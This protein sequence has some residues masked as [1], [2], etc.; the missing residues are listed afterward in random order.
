MSGASQRKPGVR[1]P[2][3]LRWFFAIFAPWFFPYTAALAGIA[4]LV[5]LPS[6]YSR[7]EHALCDRAVETLLASHDLVEVTRAGIIVREVGCN[8]GG[9]LSRAGSGVSP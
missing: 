6:P 7:E 5:S 1:V 2:P 9:R 8:I 4:Y 3:G